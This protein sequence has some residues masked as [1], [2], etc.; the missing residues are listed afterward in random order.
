MDAVAILSDDVVCHILPNIV[1]LDDVYEFNDAV[2]V[3]SDA[4]VCHI[5][6]NI[7]LLDDVYE[8][9]EALNIFNAVI[10]VDEDTNPKLVICCDEL[11]T[12]FGKVAMPSPNEDVATN[13]DT[14]PAP[15]TQVYPSDN[16]AVNEELTF[17]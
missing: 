10:S 4:V 11:T 2:A 16:D 14:L 13:L 17:K 1:L 12:P 3:L 15:P 9:N 7:V 8:F 6:P 5:L